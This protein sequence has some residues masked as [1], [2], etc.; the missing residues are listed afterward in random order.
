MYSAIHPNYNIVED[1]ST[2]YWI[3]DF[4]SNGVKLRDYLSGDTEFNYPGDT[5]IYAAFAEAPF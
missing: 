3:M 5:F 4:V 2:S 1:N